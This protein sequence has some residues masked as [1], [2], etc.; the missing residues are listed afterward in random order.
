MFLNEA[1][2]YLR[3]K[4]KELEEEVR[5]VQEEFKHYRHKYNLP[6]VR[7]VLIT[8]INKQKFIIMNPLTLQVGQ[9]APLI[10]SLIDANSLAAIPGATKV[11]KSRTVDTPAVAA[12]DANGNLQGLSAGSANLIDVNT[13]TYTDEDTNQSVTADESTTI[14]ILITPAAE[15][16]EQTVSLGPVSAIPSAPAPSGAATPLAAAVASKS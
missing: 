4:E 10:E 13:W 15:G 8:I 9:Q 5:I 16:V 7:Q 2:L 3:R 12:V 11:N 6:K 14:G 1:M